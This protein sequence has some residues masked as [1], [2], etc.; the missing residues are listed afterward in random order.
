MRISGREGDDYEFR[1][2]FF[3]FGDAR[4]LSEKTVGQVA[5]TAALTQINGGFLLTWFT[6]EWN[7]KQELSNVYCV[8]LFKEFI[9]SGFLSI[10]R[11]P[12]PFNIINSSPGLKNAFSFSDE[13]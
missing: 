6:G 8:I 4:Y 11:C 9:Y 5:T 3:H 12:A 2:R 1:A 13:P 10:S 7:D